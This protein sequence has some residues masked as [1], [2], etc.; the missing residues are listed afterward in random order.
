M[1][2]RID[3]DLQAFFEEGSTIY[4]HP[5]AVAC[6]RI[7]R[8]RTAPELLDS[9]L[10]AG[11][12]LTRYLAGIALC[13]FACRQEEMI[14]ELTTSLNGS[15]AWGRFLQLIQE[16]SRA[17]VTHPA[18]PYLN[19]GF[20]PRRGS[21]QGPTEE[22]LIALLEIRNQLGHE[23]NTITGAVAQ[24]VLDTRRPFLLLKQALRGVKALIESPLFLIE[25]QELEDGKILATTLLLMGESFDPPPRTLV[26][27][28]GIRKKWQ[29]YLALNDQAINLWPFLLWHLV[30]SRQNYRLFFIDV[31]DP[32]RVVYKS[33]SGDR[34]ETSRDLGET[35]QALLCGEHRESEMLVLEEGETLGRFW[36]IEQDKRLAAVRSVGEEI[37][38]QALDDSTV[39]WFAARL[40]SEAQVSSREVIREKLLDGRTRIDADEA[41]QLILLLGKP[42]EVKKL[43]R[44]PI[45][46]LRARKSETS[47]WDE[48]ELVEND[49]LLG[50]LRRAVAFLCRHLNNEELAVENLSSTAGTPDYIAVREALVNLF[51]HQDYKDAS[52]PGQITIERNYTELFNPGFSLVD[53]RGLQEG[54][55]SQSRNPLIARAFRLLGFAELAGSGIRALREAWA[56]EKR[57]PPEVFSDRKANNF[58]VRLDW[59]PVEEN[60]DAFFKE[61]LGVSVRTEEVALLGLLVASPK[62]VEE[63][64]ADSGFSRDEAMDY[65]E[66]LQL[67]GLVLR[68]KDFYRIRDD[69]SDLVRQRFL[70]SR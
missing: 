34:Y 2:C 39:E 61:K 16:V 15:L 4:A 7:C 25:A 29:V 28:S 70:E 50:A 1:G 31:V 49:N 24:S 9:T 6:G 27:Q 36:R 13:S 37:P 63:L 21:K 62:R 17:K 47:R 18:G 23:L 69:L 54:N 65:L 8:A 41:I 38:W 48:R 64:I 14:C 51:I 12:I 33:L 59:R 52:A 30:E 20:G 26:L 58:T 67:Q 35:L 10:R 68:E 46:D 66:Q 57:R 60:I 40:D 19:A 22:A 3:P 53:E 11:E 42:G 5:V 45:L 55:K 32:N 43:C 44:R 56:R